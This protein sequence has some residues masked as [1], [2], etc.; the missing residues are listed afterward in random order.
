[1]KWDITA[2]QF[3]NMFGSIKAIE[4]GDPFIHIQQTAWMKIIIR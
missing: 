3:Q 2:A 1:M 4:N